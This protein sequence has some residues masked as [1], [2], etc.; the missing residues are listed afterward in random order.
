MAAARRR[1]RWDALDPRASP[2]E[3]RLARA[4]ARS[5]ASTLAGRGA[6]AV[7]LGGSWARGD[8]HRESDIDL[9][10]LGAR[11]KDEV[12][13]RE[14][15]MVTLRTTTERRERTRLRNPPYVG[16]SV[17]GWRVA[18]PLHDPDR[19]GRRLKAEARRFRWEAIAARCDRWVA[20]QTVE[21]AEEAVKLVRSLAT[22]NAATAAVQRDLLADHLGFVMAIHR[23]MFWDSENGF[24]ERV[25]R[26]VGGAWA[27]DQRTAL[28]IPRA[29]LDE[30]CTAALAL[31]AET[32]RAVWSLLSTEQRAI[33]SNTCRV[34]GMPLAEAAGSR[35]A[36]T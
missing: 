30:G 21:W 25:G 17:P 22:G 28:G 26:E 12:L 2:A 33:V 1:A 34:A 9:W 10:V 20:D 18:V 11:L 3:R 6:R 29:T 8:A 32:A 13:W 24:W 14:P 19:I 5:V 16:G 23:R 36:G 35:A 31:Y 4:V 27:R 7:V 15:F